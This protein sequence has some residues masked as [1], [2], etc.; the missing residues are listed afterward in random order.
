MEKKK[1]EQ[2]REYFRRIDV[3]SKKKD[4][5]DQTDEEESSHGPDDVHLI[6]V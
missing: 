6:R 3:S 4:K 1:K 2:L 5:V